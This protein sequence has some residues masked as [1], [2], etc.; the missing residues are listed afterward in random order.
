MQRRDRDAALGHRGEVG[1][2]LV[3]VAGR[4]AVDPVLTPAGLLVL[5]LEL[6]AVDALAE[7][8]DLDAGGLARGHVDV[9]QRAA[10]QRHVLDLLDDPGGEGRRG[11]EVELAAEPE[12]HLARRGLLGDGDRRQA[13]HDALERGGHGAGVGDVVAEVGAVVDARDDQLGL[14]ALDEPERGEADAVHG[15]P[16]GR[17]ADGAVAERDLLH[18]QRPP[19]GDPA[20]DRGAVGVRRDDGELD[21]GHLQQRAPQ[22]L[23]ALGLDPVVVGEQDAHD[24]EDK[25]AIRPPRR[26]RRPA[27][28]PQACAAAGSGSAPSCMSSASG[29]QYIADSAHC[30]PRRSA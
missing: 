9:E 13:E 3:A 16:V 10:G 6:V 7:P 19:G 20:A 25:P 26:A 14:E 29:L 18:P 8:G 24:R 17:V 1:A 23:Q 28:A 5:E 15:R 27:R 30:S 22:R 21:P 11:V 2:L 12:V 4:V